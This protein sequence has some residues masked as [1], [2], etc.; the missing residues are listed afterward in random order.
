[1]KKVE[2]NDEAEA[3][4]AFQ[5]AMALENLKHKYICGYKEFFC[6]WDKEV[7]ACIIFVSS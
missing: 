2:C 6:Y 5:E 7:R 4:K 1:L 3:A